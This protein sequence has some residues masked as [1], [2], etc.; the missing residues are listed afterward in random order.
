MHLNKNFLQFKDFYKEQIIKTLKAIDKN[1]TTEVIKLVARAIRKN[2]NTIYIFGNG[3]SYSIACQ[4]GINLADKLKGAGHSIRINYGVDF[5]VAQSLSSRGQ[6]KNIFTDA[7]ETEKA[8]CNDLVMLISGSG[9]SDNILR[10]ADFC[11]KHK[12]PAVSFSGFNGGKLARKKITHNI[13]AAVPDQ[14][15]CEDVI[16]ILLHIISDGV[17]KKINHQPYWLE[18][19][20]QDKISSIIN[21]FNEV[22]ID[23][24]A[25]ISKAVAEAFMN[26]K[27][28]F[29]LG[30]EGHGLSVS[31]EHTAHNFN[32]D[33]V[34]Q[35]KTPPRRNLV[36]SPTYTDFSGVGND[37]LIP[38]VATIQQ[39]DKALEG[40]VALFFVHNFANPAVQHTIDKANSR[41]MKIF[42]I[43]GS[44]CNYKN[45]N[46]CNIKS[47]SE[48]FSA[49]I[50]QM[51]GH[52]TA[53]LV[54]CRLKIALR[55]LND[56]QNIFFYLV[57]KDMAQRRLIDRPDL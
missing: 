51:L 57:N 32:W 34:F 21:S 50:S 44:E 29:V 12:I 31:A 26:N 46:C 11:I 23:F 24:L 43:T 41:Q 19:L 2:K 40:D 37:R 22:K 5:H 35:I 16:Q 18:N 14:Q 39:L 53:R 30:P 17:I 8:D 49:N 15:I 47:N 52:I 7:L 1:S 48:S 56:R 20:F 38:G 55:E 25:E 13:I 45:H 27:T 4:F 33:T 3:G 54:R 36:S 10:A 42:I 6:Y 9:D 28:V